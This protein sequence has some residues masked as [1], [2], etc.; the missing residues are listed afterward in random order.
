MNKTFSPIPR[1]CAV[2]LRWVLVSLWGVVVTAC[3]DLTSVVP[4]V[5]P[6][7]G[8]ES[9]ALFVLCDGNY[10]LNNSSLALYDAGDGH[11]EKDF[12]QAMTGRKL[13]DTGNDLQRY[14]DKLYIVVT[15]SSQIE[16]LEAQTGKSLKQIP[17]FDGSLARQPRNIA[18]W[19]DKAYVCS[20]DGTVVRI[21]TTSL[22]VEAT[23]KVGRHPD[24]LSAAN[25][26]LYVANSGGLDYGDPL[27]Y[28]NTVSVVDLSTF[29]E[30]TRLTV[31]LNPYRVRTDDRGY[32]WVAC[33]GNYTDESGSLWCLD[34]GSDRVVDSYPM[35]VTNM[36]FNGPLAYCYYFDNITS[37]ADIL[38]FNLLTGT[39]ERESFITDGTTLKTPYGI[40][41]DQMSGDVYLTDAG[42]Y[43]SAGSVYC[44]SAE[45]RLKFR[46]EQ[47]GVSPN[48]V[49]YVPDYVGSVVKPDTTVAPANYIYKVFAYVPA[50]GQFVGQYP[51]WVEG[52]DAEALRLKAEARLKG[53]LGGLVTL[54][55]FG[56]RID[57]GFA[58]AV[59][60]KS[61][62][63]DFKVYGNAVLG[64]AEP[65][66]VAVAVDVNANGL[67]DDPWYELAGSAH[68]NPL[69]VKDYR[70]VYH[71]PNNQ[72]D[73]VPYT[74]NRGGAG[75]LRPGYP[76]WMGDSLV[77]TGTLL[78]PTAIQDQNTG[79][80]TL[81]TLDWGYAD[82]HLNSSSKIAFDLDWAVDAAGRPVHL[83]SI[84]F[85]R[86]YTAVN[87][88]A[89]WLGELSTEVS[90]AEV[91]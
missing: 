34:S 77:C 21:D 47:V 52:D 19:D 54:G 46:L 67:P 15:A 7:T 59:F 8:L 26:K 14:G 55:R 75:L 6:V 50:P 57:F 61:G 10:S 78:P 70:I 1:P 60:N 71:K 84:H 89:G 74:D 2:I 58:G 30:T 28:D 88:E 90:G 20:F 63:T 69:T 18:F 3:D 13:G 33:R 40:S 29:T 45:G 25:G 9:G 35:A 91:F 86:V 87:Q 81:K 80:W 16:V 49:M 38:V 36:A 24:G 83:D 39:V 62:Q 65:G 64:G 43:V 41:V 73:S 12:F 68:N 11:L 32:V 37:T 85:V 4:P 23:T 51:A 72:A 5:T 48:T 22:L 44:F 53:R 82:N 79:Y 17:L 31:G 76:A 42:D 56:G 27:G 66:I